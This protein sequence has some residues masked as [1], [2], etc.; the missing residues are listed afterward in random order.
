MKNDIAM[1]ISTAVGSKVG[2]IL[3][4]TDTEMKVL[5]FGQLIGYEVPPPDP[6]LQT[7]NAF[8]ASAV[9]NN[10]ITPKIKLEN[11]EIVWGCECWWGPRNMIELVIQ[12]AKE[13]GKKIIDIK[14]SEA[15]KLYT[16]KE[17]NGKF[18]M[19]KK[20]PIPREKV[21][22]ARGTL[23]KEFGEAEH[24]GKKLPYLGIEDGRVK[25]VCSRCRSR[26]TFGKDNGQ[27]LLKVESNG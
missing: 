6:I 18:V 19:E 27:Y 14:P 25:T 24:C 10:S 15:R 23:I 20:S 5:G 7:I 4:R 17:L 13:E 3:T 9:T 1:E 8:Y 26:L 11:D 2:C 21:T 22:D 12:R 16:P